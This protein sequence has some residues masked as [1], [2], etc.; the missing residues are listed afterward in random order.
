MI[1]YDG[2]M[3]YRCN[4]TGKLVTEG[5]HCWLDHDS[6]GAYPRAHFD[7]VCSLADYLGIG[8]GVLVAEWRVCGPDGSWW[9]VLMWQ[10]A[11]KFR[12]AGAGI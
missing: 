11:D 2:G 8:T 5:N 4:A 10:P 1:T 9:P 12:H 7:P 6:S 3:L